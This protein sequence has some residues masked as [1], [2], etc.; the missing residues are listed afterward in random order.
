LGRNLLLRSV[1]VL[2][3]RMAD[4]FGCV[5]V[6][7]DATPEAVAFYEK[8]G[9]V[10][11]ETVAGQLGDRPQPAPMFLELGRAIAARSCYRSG[12]ISRAQPRRKKKRAPFDCV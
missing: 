5:G 1:L 9:F 6:L 4:D 7:V 10:M 8:L 12:I 2:E 11:L 3:K